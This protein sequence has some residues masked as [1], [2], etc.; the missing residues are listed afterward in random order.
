MPIHVDTDRNIAGNDGLVVSIDARIENDAIRSIG[1]IVCMKV[2]LTNEDAGKTGEDDKR[3]VMETRLEERQSVA[4]RE[5]P[6][7]LQFAVHWSAHRLGRMIGCSVTTLR[8]NRRLSV[9]SRLAGSTTAKS[10]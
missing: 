9:R 2:H 7:M 10:R 1:R 6:A 4:M 5:D 8:A 3:C